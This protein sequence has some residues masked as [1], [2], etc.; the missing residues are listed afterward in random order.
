MAN[1]KKTDKQD[2]QR[3]AELA[4]IHIAKA[5]LGLDD[6]TYRQ[7]LY[8]LFGKT[9]AGKLTANERAELLD[10]FKRSGFKTHNPKQSVKS[11]KRALISKIDAQ[12]YS[13]KL[14]R[15]YADGIAMQMYGTSKFVWCSEE[16]LSS[17]ITALAKQQTE[18]Q[19]EGY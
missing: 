17:I 11:S 16:Q 9:S 7:K 15:N 10:N 4:K 8:G 3:K 12:L 19:K 2:P 6:E 18:E 1:S 14:R 5:Q 13:M